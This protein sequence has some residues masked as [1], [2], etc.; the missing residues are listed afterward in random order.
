MSATT[1]EI[2]A[3]QDCNYETDRQG[4]LDRHL[5]SLKHKIKV[6]GITCCDLTYYDKHQYINHKR[7]EKHRFRI[8][9]IDIDTHHAKDLDERD[10]LATQEQLKASAKGILGTKAKISL[11]LTPN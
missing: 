4:K 5:D 7:S 1:K 3:C 10:L 8:K 11:N 9:G 6:H 2:F